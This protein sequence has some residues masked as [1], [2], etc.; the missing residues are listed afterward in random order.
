MPVAATAFWYGGEGDGGGGSI[1]GAEGDRSAIGGRGGGGG[2]L[3]S[4]LPPIRLA[5]WFWSSIVTVIAATPRIAKSRNPKQ[6]QGT[7]T[8]PMMR[9]APPLPFS[10]RTSRLLSVH[11]LRPVGALSSSSNSASLRRLLKVNL[12]ASTAM[13]P[14]GPSD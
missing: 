3:G 2:G 9:V 1:Y 11:G 4:I 8:H 5:A 7:S 14:T 13:A 10:P 12:L 6:Q